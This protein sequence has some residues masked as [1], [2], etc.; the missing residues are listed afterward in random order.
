MQKLK[1]GDQVQVIS[2]KEASEKNLSAKRGK[3]L[4]IDRSADRVA[5]EG[6]RLVKRHIRKGRDPKNP[7]GGI[8][9]KPGTIARSAVAVVCKKCDRP[10]RIGIRIEG[11]KKVR[12]CRK[13]DAAID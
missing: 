6:L 13:C 11:E 1:I 7:E 8:L 9:E 3:L 5:V 4:R 10:T 2:G 12:F